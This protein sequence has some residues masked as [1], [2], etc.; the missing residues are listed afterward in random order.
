MEI[1]NPKKSHAN[2]F[3]GSIEFNLRNFRITRRKFIFILL[4]IIIYNKTIYFI[5]KLVV[6][7]SIFS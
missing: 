7:A 3:N 4:K 1:L 2:F 6:I 5:E